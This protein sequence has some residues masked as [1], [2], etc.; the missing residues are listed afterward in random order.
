[1]S[2]VN[3]SVVH[4]ASKVKRLSLERHLL[5][6]CYLRK[7]LIT[8]GQ[9]QNLFC[10]TFSQV[11]RMNGTEDVRCEVPGLHQLCGSGWKQLASDSLEEFFW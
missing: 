1:M 6:W 8:D 7:P 3:A 11:Q 9:L 5:L 10:F 2:I 4:K